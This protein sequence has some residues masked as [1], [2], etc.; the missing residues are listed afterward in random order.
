MPPVLPLH[1]SAQANQKEQRS[2]TRG[3]HKVVE[4]SRQ[5]KSD[6]RT[7]HGCSGHRAIPCRPNS[8][9]HRDAR[10]RQKSADADGPGFEPQH[11]IL[12]EHTPGG[13]SVVSEDP[14]I[15]TAREITVL[16]QN[17][18]GIVAEVNIADFDPM[19]DWT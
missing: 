4:Q 19:T 14:E 10:E 7:S 13:M 9:G 5:K 11:Q 12:V 3:L 16:Q 18:P 6:D 15:E 8:T 2:K 1:Q 17:A